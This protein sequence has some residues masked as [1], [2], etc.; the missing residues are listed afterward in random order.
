MFVNNK[1]EMISL[2][3]DWYFETD[4]IFIVEKMSIYMEY[5]NTISVWNYSNLKVNFIY[6][7]QI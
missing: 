5:F 3:F 6:D 4:S 2:F 1:R 7:N